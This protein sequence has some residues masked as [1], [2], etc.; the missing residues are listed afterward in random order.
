[1]KKILLALFTLSLFYFGCSDLGTNVNPS[2][3]ASSSKTA[4]KLPAKTSASIE[5]VFSASK[6]IAGNKGGSLELHNGYSSVR[7][8]VTVDA[9]LSIPAGAYKGVKNITMQVGD[10]AAIDFSPSMVFDA[11][12]TLTL[13]FTGVNLLG[14]DPSSVNFY[15]FA[16][17]GSTQLVNNDGIIVDTQ[18]GTLE[19]INAKLPHFSRYSW[20]K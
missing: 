4:I 17:D 12:L 7:G 18:S 20:A 3:V 11:P 6:L 2:P 8:N 1:M 5:G 10:D 16:P 15:Y 19:I 9:E 13:K 14:V